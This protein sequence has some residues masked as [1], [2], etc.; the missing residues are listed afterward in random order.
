MRVT[1]VT[2][3][4]TPVLCTTHGENGNMRETGGGTG[5]EIKD[6]GEDE[7][8]RTEQGNSKTKREWSGGKSN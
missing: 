3:A 7:G 8:G 2:P 1:I 5:K 4:G 6:G